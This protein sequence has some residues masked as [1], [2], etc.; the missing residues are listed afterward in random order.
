MEA[1]AKHDFTATADDELSFRKGDKL[2]ILSMEDDRNWYKAELNGREGYIPSNYIDMKPHEWY[3]SRI[4]RLDAEQTLLSKNDRDQFTQ[5]DGAFLIRP[6]ESSPGEFSLSVKF[7]EGVQHFKVLRDGEGKYF[8]WVVKFDSLNELVK[9]HRTASV[10]R[11]QTIFLQDMVWPKVMANYDFHPAGDDELELRR[12]DIVTIID[13]RID[14][15]W[16]MG[17][18][19]RGNRLCRGL[20]PKTYVSD[21]T[22]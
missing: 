11:S 15:N 12:G 9:Y 22:A 8:L 21:Y 20:I 4:G 18:I 2:K 19:M 17:E 1:I 10:S 5:K 16:W 13:K 7:G 14:E 3:V 6:S